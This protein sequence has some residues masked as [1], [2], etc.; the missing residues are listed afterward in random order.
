[1]KSQLTSTSPPT[2]RSTS[3]LPAQKENRMKPLLSSLVT[4][5]LFLGGL[6]ACAGARFVVHGAQHQHLVTLAGVGLSLVTGSLVMRREPLRSWLRT[7]PVLW[8]LFLFNLGV[9]L[10][11]SF[12]VHGT[13]GIMAAVG[14][15]VVALGAGVGLLR[16]RPQP[17]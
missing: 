8:F 14:L 11:V 13:Q 4:W 6:V 15:G 7:R 2:A 12:L 10:T 17:D 9:A 16:R 3:Q 1:M 5:L